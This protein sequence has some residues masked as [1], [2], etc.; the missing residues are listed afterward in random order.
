MSRRY[1]VIVIG[2]GHNGLTAAAYVARAGLKV[3]VLERRPTAGGCAATEEFH[4]GYR[5]DTYAHRLGAF[6]PRVARDLAL[7]RQGV[8]FVR[9]DPARL[10]LGGGRTLLLYRSPERTA[11]AL[12]SLDPHDAARWPAFCRRIADAVSLLEALRRR[13]PPSMPAP[14]LGDLAALARAA[15]GLRLRGRSR[16]AELLRLLPMSAADL[17]DEWFQDPLLKGALAASA[18]SGLMLGPYG[19]GTVYGLLQHLGPGEHPGSEVVLVRGGM[20]RLVAALEAAAQKAGAEIRR[21]V[22][23]ER[24]VGEDGGGGCV[25]L[26]A[27]ESLSARA[28]VSTLDPKRTLLGLVGPERLDP[29]VARQ[30]AHLRLRGVVAKVHLALA[31]LP[32][33]AGAA[34]EDA[35]QGAITVAPSVEYVERAYDDAKYGRISQHPVLEAVIPTLRDPGLAPAGGHVMSVMVQ[36]APYRLEG[37]A[38]D[39]A[40]RE[41]LAE[42]VVQR[43]A[44]YAPDLPRAVVGRQVLAPPDLEDRLGLTE[45]D[46]FHGQPALDQTWFMRPLA[47]WARYRLPVPG[48]YLG[49]AGAHPGGGVT[50]GPGYGVARA[51]LR[52]LRRR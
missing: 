47:G 13:D 39:A 1:D 18:V 2:A 17:L 19:A 41:A 35:L 3:L 10:A 34:G 38:W 50:A 5:A 51:V 46:I 44:E 42:A 29:A 21:G 52:D 36:Y 16:F 9:P 48:L 27:G 30:V 45:G 32:R 37:G 14:S 22:A 26:A 8:E 31:E 33:F 12:Q 20:E 11:S 25:V 43:L 23:A 49:G 15:L 7:E 4:P 28:V 40:R 6:D 24:V